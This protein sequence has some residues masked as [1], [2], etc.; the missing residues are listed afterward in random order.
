LGKKTGR[1]TKVLIRRQGTGFLATGRVTG[2][3]SRFETAKERRKE[4]LDYK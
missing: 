2:A 3:E 1:I 4:K